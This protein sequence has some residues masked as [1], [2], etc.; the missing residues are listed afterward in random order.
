MIDL[1]N[2]FQNE[3][4]PLHGDRGQEQPAPYRPKEWSIAI[5]RE[6]GSQGG[7]IG[8]RLGKRFNWRV[9][10]REL[11]EYLC[12]N[13]V[14]REEVLADIPT[15]ANHW[16]EERLHQLKHNQLLAPE[17]DQ[18][19]MPR[20]V[21]ALAARG[22]V[23]FVGAGAGFYLPRDTSLH[24]RICAPL[25]ERITYM[26]QLLRQSPEE[27]LQSLRQRDQ[28]RTQYLQQQ[29]GARALDPSEFDLTINSNQFG[30]EGTTELIIVAF[31]QKQA[32][33]E[34]DSSDT[35]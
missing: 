24:V 35:D 23:I 32:Q 4:I 30:E 29:F 5:S 9:Y 33:W 12:G 22:G 3:T 1:Q 17:A 34:E 28:R 10:D 18:G 26:G 6:A 20:L 7:S 13:P 21:L 25:E 31:H 27:A 8:K 14:A 16:I 19:E 2:E 15:E 11:L